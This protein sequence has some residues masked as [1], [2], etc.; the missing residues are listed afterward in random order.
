MLTTAPHQLGAYELVEEIGRGGMGVVYKA[1]RPRSMVKTLAI[2]KRKDSGALAET[3]Y[4]FAVGS[5][6]GVRPAGASRS[7]K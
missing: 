2:I 4:R 1:L 3:L 6:R 7:G 5:F